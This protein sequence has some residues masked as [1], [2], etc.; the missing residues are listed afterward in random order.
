LKTVF[1]LQAY[2]AIDRLRHKDILVQDV[3]VQR[4]AKSECSKANMLPIDSASRS[5]QQT[6][7]DFLGS[8][9]EG[10]REK[11]EAKI[12]SIDGLVEVKPLYKLCEENYQ[13]IKGSVTSFYHLVTILIHQNIL[14]HY[15]LF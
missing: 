2:L 13:L 1:P 4:L 12:D 10:H 5:A 9:T 15:F 8:P 11:G 3:A 6:I 14:Y 7:S